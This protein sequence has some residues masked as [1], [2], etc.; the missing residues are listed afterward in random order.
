VDGEGQDGAER[1][2]E[3]TD[4]DTHDVLLAEATGGDGRPTP[5]E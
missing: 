3:D 5:D 1:D 2:Q 4:T